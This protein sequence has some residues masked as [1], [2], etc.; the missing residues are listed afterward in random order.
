MINLQKLK[1][2]NLSKKYI[3]PREIFDALPKNKYGYLRYVQQEVLDEWFKNKDKEFNIIKMNTGSGKTIVALI[4]LVSLMN[5]NGGNAVYIVPDNFLVEQ[6]CNQANDLG[7]KVTKEY[8]DL[9]FL[10]KK[11]ILVTTIKTLVNGKSVFGMRENNNKEIDN[12]I[13][14]DVHS[15]LATI[16]DQSKVTIPN[17][18]L[19][20]NEI[21]NLIKHDLSSYKKC[22]EQF[23]EDEIYS[24]VSTIIPFW[25]W[26]NKIPL[27]KECLNKYSDEEFYT[28]NY[29]LIKDD[30]NLCRCFFRNNYIEIIP[31]CTPIHKIKSYIKA[32]HKIFLSATLP[33]DTIFSTVLNVPESELSNII[34]PSSASDIGERMIL[35]PQLINPLIKDEEIFNVAKNISAKINV[36]VIV[37]SKLRAKAWEPYSDMTILSE[38][39][40]VGVETIKLNNHGLYVFV[41]KY[42]G[43]DLPD[44]DCRLIILDRLP[45]LHNGFDSFEKS[46]LSNSN[47]I[48]S[49][50][51]QKLEQGMGRGIRSNSDYCGVLLMGSSLVDL[52]FSNNGIKFFSNATRKQ[53]ELSMD[54]WEQMKNQSLQEIVENF[55]LLIDRNQEWVSTSRDILVDCKYDSLVNI[56]SLQLQIRNSYNEAMRGNYQKATSILE[57][58][59]NSL[60]NNEE[61]GYV[62]MLIA[63]YMDNIDHSKAQELLLSGYRDNQYILKPIEGINY[64]KIN[65]LNTQSNNILKNIENYNGDINKFIIKINSILDNLIFMPDTHEQFEE[66]L[67]ELFSL[68]GYTSQR[69]EK[70]FNEGPDNLIQLEN[71]Y[72]VVECKNGAITDEIC[73]ADSSQLNESISWFKRKYGEN[74]DFIPVMI[75]NSNIFS[76]QSA[77]SLNTKI[78]TPS[79]LEI[80]K[81]NIKNF[82]KSIS[83]NL[84]TLNINKII[85]SNR[86]D[87]TGILSIL[88]E[89][90]INN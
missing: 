37:P 30:L 66:S 81:S 48:N 33:N 87:E 64:S 90:S 7:I 4:I 54:L 83:A 79:L 23:L 84:T 46:C 62:K 39:L 68:I 13:I 42:D 45:G 41:N 15:C 11:S 47:R 88:G 6:V 74:L 32:K 78:I 19:A 49:E 5:D 20:Y 67:K 57:T 17:T 51:L 44:N 38:N 56:D 52:I 82:L 16:E 24:G 1:L 77:P 89:Y 31:Y 26:N 9:S 53:I 86:I 71:T 40:L 10:Q 69:P 58:Y 70:Q 27:I 3:K 61:I 50:Y 80:L 25:I 34:I 12:I 63:E 85:Q 60:T 28:F 35:F 76:K 2:D 14:D 43:I 29:Q 18:C 72:L 8:N 75:H 21:Y 59:K 22:N 55:N 73:K 36:V 65:K